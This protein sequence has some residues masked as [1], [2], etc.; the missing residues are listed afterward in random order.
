MSKPA[1]LKPRQYLK[2]PKLWVIDYRIGGKRERRFFK[3]KAL[4]QTAIDRVKIKIAKGGIDALSLGDSLRLMAFEG[5]EALKPYNKTIADAVTF[6]VNHLKASQRSITVAALVERYMATQTRNSEVHQKDLSRRYSRFCASFG[7]RPVHTVT[8]LEIKDWI[9]ALNPAP[10]SFNNWRDRLGF[11]FGYAVEEKV[12]AENPIDKR[13]KRR[14]T[15]DEA[16]EIFTIDELSRLLNAATP[17]LL[18]ILAIGAFT[19][20]RTAELMR[21][22]WQDVN[23]ATG[24][25][26]VKG[27]KAKSRRHRSIEMHPNLKEWLAPYKGRTGKIWNGT[28]NMLYYALRG[29]CKGSGLATWPNNGL[30]H[31]YASHFLVRYEN[32]NLLALNL[33]HVGSDLIF[34]NYRALVTKTDAER[35]FEIRPAAPASNILPMNSAVA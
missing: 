26:S 9:D 33:G 14:E 35:Y 15:V 10:V 21:L 8:A 11:L 1:V 17:E 6:Y 31:S 4:A 7:P 18:P 30:R 13:F 12:L 2:N 27:R 34:S 20:I 24:F 16:P 23:F 32:Q 28:L 19:G 22:D 3:S 5:A 25:V 29:V